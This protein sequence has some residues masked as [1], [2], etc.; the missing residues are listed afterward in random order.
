MDG[1]IDTA[2][3]REIVLVTV[4]PC[5]AAMNATLARLLVDTRADCEVSHCFHLGSANVDK[6]RA[7]GW[8]VEIFTANW[9]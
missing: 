7:L 6:R 4:E 1:F 3:E 5:E 8:R 9:P 2:V